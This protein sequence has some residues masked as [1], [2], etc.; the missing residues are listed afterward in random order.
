MTFFFGFV[1]FP[2]LGKEK[3]AT[4]S[5]SGGF[6]TGS[7]LQPEGADLITALIMSISL[8]LFNPTISGSKKGSPRDRFRFKRLGAMLGQFRETSEMAI[9]LT[10]ERYRDRKQGGAQ[11]NNSS[12]QDLLGLKLT[13]IQARD[14][15]NKCNLWGVPF[16]DFMWI[17][18]VGNNPFRSTKKGHAHDYFATPKEVPLRTSATELSGAGEASAA[19][20]PSCELLP[21]LRAQEQAKCQSSMAIFCSPAK[22]F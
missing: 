14:L 19:M 20:P 18:V 4:G 7:K 22:S 15:Q 10:T 21:R 5:P 12:L 11:A 9:P 13:Q 3:Q 17:R 1:F 8:G 16:P 2:P 6:R